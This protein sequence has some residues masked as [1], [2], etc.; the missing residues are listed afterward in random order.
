MKARVCVVTAAGAALLVAAGPA[1]AATIVG[2]SKG[3]VLRGTPKAD[4]LYGKGGNDKL[5]GLAG[6]DL[7]VGGSGDDVLVGGP[8]A[9]TFQCGPGRDAALANPAARVAPDCEVVRGLP[10]PPT[11]AIKDV[12]AIEGDSGTTTVSFPVTL[13]RTSTKVV[14]VEY[15]TTDGTATAPSDYRAASGKV[16][17]NPGETSKT[18]DVAVNPDQEVESDETFQVNLS[19]AVN[20]TIA[21]SSAVGTVRNDDKPRPHTGRYAGTTS[22]GRPIQFDVAADLQTLSHLTFVPV[23]RCVEVP[24]V[25]D[26]QALDLGDTQIPI[27]PDWSFAGGGSSSDAEGSISLSVTGSLNPSGGAAGTLRVD[28]AVNTSAGVVHCSTGDVSW[29]AS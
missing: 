12:S 3:D 23:I 16:T 14:S 10:P 25:V 28:L 6:N 26:N 13:S 4:K 11:I 20:G 22:Q 18:I 5:Y 17:F 2:T 27:R 1:A 9:D 15:T 24:V 29:T 8:G 7:L 21:T 19:G